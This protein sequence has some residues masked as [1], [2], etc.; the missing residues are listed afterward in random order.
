MHLLVIYI[1][2]ASSFSV[3]YEQGP[4]SLTQVVPRLSGMGWQMKQP[5]LRLASSWMP[6]F[7]KTLISLFSDVLLLKQNKDS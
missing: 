2:I 4:L 7:S 3:G 1:G 6:L 5:I